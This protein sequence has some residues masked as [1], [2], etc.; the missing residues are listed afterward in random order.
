MPIRFQR[1]AATAAVV[2]GAGLIALATGGV[3]RLDGELA[4]ASTTAPPSRQILETQMVVH[5]CHHPDA[6]GQP[7]ESPSGEQM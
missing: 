5:R 3:A 6:P 7:A 4:A 1:V 2:S